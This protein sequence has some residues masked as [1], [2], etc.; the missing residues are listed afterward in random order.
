MDQYGCDPADRLCRETAEF[1]GRPTPA[2]AAATS[3]T[4]WE[5]QSHAELA[6]AWVMLPLMLLALVSRFWQRHSDRR[7]TPGPAGIRS[8]CGKSV[9]GSCGQPRGPR[10]QLTGTHSGCAQHRTQDPT[11]T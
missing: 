3:F 11:S 9:G 1:E 6:V 7:R 5:P 8:R 10:V 4:A 2:G